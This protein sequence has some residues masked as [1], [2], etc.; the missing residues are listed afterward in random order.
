[1]SLPKVNYTV[2]RSEVKPGLS[3]AYIREG[4][5]GYPLLLIHGFPETKRIWYRNIGPLTAAGFEVI[6]PDLRGFG[7]SDL[8]ADGFYDPAAYAKDLYT[9]VHDVLGHSRC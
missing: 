9:L 1:M 2:H 7:E 8:S 4:V 3:L 5:G 6:A